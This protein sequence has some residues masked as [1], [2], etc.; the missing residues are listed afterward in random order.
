MIDH[1]EIFTIVKLKVWLWVWSKVR[2]A[3][4]SYSDRCLEPLVCMK[5]IKKVFGGVVKDLGGCFDL[6]LC[7][8]C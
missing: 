4:F 2:L 5:S 6:Q 7:L 1:I 8:M 3:S